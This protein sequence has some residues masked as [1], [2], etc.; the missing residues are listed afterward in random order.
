MK[1]DD[2]DGYS[3]WCVGETALH[4][5]IE[6]VRACS[7]DTPA[8]EIAATEAIWWCSALDD[9]HRGRLGDR[10]YFA[11]RSSS[12]EGGV[13]RGLAYVRNLSAHQLALGPG[14][15]TVGE[16]L[17]PFTPTWD[18]DLGE[19]VRIGLQPV[20]IRWRPIAELPAPERPERHR[21]DDAYSQCVAGRPLLDPLVDALSFF[22]ALVWRG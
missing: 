1:P 5:A 9:W 4:A 2:Q 22:D 12:R 8:T 3:A 19:I 14:F 17:V 13:V 16:P 15:V 20:E 11:L 21:R 18:E 6:R 10:S 7:E